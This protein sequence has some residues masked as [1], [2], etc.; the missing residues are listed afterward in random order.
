MGKKRMMTF[1]DV[2]TY[3][4]GYAF[5]PKDYSLSG[6]QIIRIQDLTG[7][8][9]QTNY[10]EGTLPEKYVVH[11]GDVLISWSASLGVYCWNNADA[12]LNQHIFKVVFDKLNLDKDY[13]VHQ[14]SYR[15]KRAQYLAHG[16]TMTHLTK[17]VFDELPFFVP[18][19][20]GQRKVASTLDMV[21]K[22]ITIA[23]QMLAK[24]D[25]LI[26]SRFVEMFGDPI[27]DHH[28]N[29]K[30]IDEICS[31]K[32]GP[33]G[34]ALHKEDYIDNGHCVINPMHVINGKVYPDRSFSV[35]TKKYEELKAYH[36]NIGDVVLGRRGEIGRC[37]IVLQ[38]GLLCGTGSMILRPSKVVNSDY[39]QR[40]IA[41]SSVRYS[42][43]QR[44]V[45]VTMKNLNA[46]TVGET[47]ISVPPLALQN[48]FAEFVTQVESLKTT[49]RQ[50]LDRLNT[51]YDSLAQRYFAE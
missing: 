21:Q 39:L 33:F 35:D 4:N 49:T 14:A 16:A 13:F 1:G 20:E 30:R 22:Q 17:K 48:E 18:S 6:L 31:L 10:Y 27:H 32:I 9:Y 26:Q 37:G 50:Q 36:L 47:V 38:K 28:F 34:S 25:E 40:V 8:A 19:L 7:N 41:S 46:K 3:V 24:A 51:L 5:K 45:G 15:I 44:S 43:E 2:A 42:L 29:E 12:Y 11:S 23:E